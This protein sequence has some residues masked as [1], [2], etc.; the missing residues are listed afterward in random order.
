MKKVAS[1]RLVLIDK[2]ITVF[3]LV[4]FGVFRPDFVLMAG[5]VLAVPYLFLTKRLNMLKHLV[6]ATVIAATWVIIA[7][8]EYFYNYNFLTVFGV[9]IYPFFAWA[10]GLLG[11]Y[12]IFSYYRMR[13]ES[14]KFIK[15]FLLF[16]FIYWFLL[17]FGEMVAYHVLRVR[18]L[19]TAAYDTLPI[20]NCMHAA[21]WMKF[22]YFLIGP[23]FFII[24][25]VLGWEN[26]KLF[27][28]DKARRH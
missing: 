26:R 14:K 23:T 20:C 16:I 25:Y 7:R 9:N 12:L 22:A 15:Q 27:K 8:K 6:L 11:V 19:A 4:L 17:L 5:Y 10:L 13:I 3:V 24:G 21:T 2:L 18:N 1:R 28:D